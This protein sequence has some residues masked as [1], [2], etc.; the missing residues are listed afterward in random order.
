MADRPLT[1]VA[2]RDFNRGMI[3]AVEN[4]NMPDQAVRLAINANFDRISIVELRPGYVA[5]AS[6]INGTNSQLVKS[7]DATTVDGVVGRVVG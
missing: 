2:Y 5:L 4:P 6:Q 1:P 3:Q 7:P